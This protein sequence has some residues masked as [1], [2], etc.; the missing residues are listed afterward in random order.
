MEWKIF[1]NYL[2]AEAGVRM[3]ST[4]GWFNHGNGNNLSGFNALPGG[5]RED[6]D[7]FLGLEHKAEFWSNTTFNGR[8]VWTRVL[9]YDN[10]AVNRL[11]NTFKSGSSITCVKD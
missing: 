9:F 10:N 6:P 4:Y 11:S 7:G 3:K 2:G 8:A 5:A 1:E